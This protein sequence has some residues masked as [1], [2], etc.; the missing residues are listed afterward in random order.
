[1]P[2]GIYAGVYVAYTRDLLQIASTKVGMEGYVPWGPAACD[3]PV[4]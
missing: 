3:S 2:L 1:M 4:G